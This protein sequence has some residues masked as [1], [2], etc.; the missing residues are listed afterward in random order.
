MASNP[1]VSVIFFFCII[2]TS[3]VKSPQ[4][5]SCRTLPPIWSVPF[6][7]RP[8]IH[9]AGRFCAGHCGCTKSKT[10]DMLAS[11]DTRLFL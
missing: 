8:A 4:Q 3:R 2:T 7:W 1:Q 10:R 6:T 9:S 5:D 11:T